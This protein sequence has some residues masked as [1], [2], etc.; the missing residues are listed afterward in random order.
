[1]HNSHIST[2]NIAMQQI[3]GGTECL[4][5]TFTEDSTGGDNLGKRCILPR[6]TTGSI[7][8]K[9]IG[10]FTGPRFSCSLKIELPGTEPRIIDTGS[11]FPS[12]KLAKEAA[13]RLAMESDTREEALRRS[14]SIGVA[15]AIRPTQST[16]AASNRVPMPAAIGEAANAA[17]ADRTRV[18]AGEGVYATSRNIR[19]HVLPPLTYVPLEPGQSPPPPYVESSTSTADSSRRTTAG[20]QRVSQTREIGDSTLR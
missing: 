13:A 12:K 20:A 8:A 10:Q 6:A 17:M 14:N 2:L 19:P 11:V 5:Y 18:L 9:Y 16:L 7:C 3:S 1:M 4:S 15:M